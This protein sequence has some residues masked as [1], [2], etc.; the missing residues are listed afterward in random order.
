MLP[1]QGLARRRARAGR[2]QP[3]LEAHRKPAVQLPPGELLGAGRPPTSWRY[4]AALPYTSALSSPQTTT[5]GFHYLLLICLIAAEAH[6]TSFA[7]QS[8]S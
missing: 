5:L 3:T 7:V 8:M 6:G 1:A 4:L 2:Q